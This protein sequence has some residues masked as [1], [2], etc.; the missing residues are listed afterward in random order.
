MKKFLQANLMKAFFSKKSLKVLLQNLTFTS[1]F[2]VSLFFLAFHKCFYLLRRKKNKLPKNFLQK[3]ICKNALKIMLQ[4]PILSFCKFRFFLP[5]KFGFLLAMFFLLSFSFDS[6]A[7]SPEIHLENEVDE[8]RANKLFLQVRCLVCGGQVIENSDSEFSFEMRKLIR[9]KIAEKK[10]D[11]EIKSELIAK[12]G[13][14]ILTEVNAKN[15]GFLLWIL[16][17]IFAIFLGGFF[18]FKLIK[19]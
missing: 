13:S 2:V 6:G 8:Q 1:N 9:A 18:V 3:Q 17:V 5:K 16:P 12:F 7:L 11:A 4:N 19:N 10:S 15:N 14:D